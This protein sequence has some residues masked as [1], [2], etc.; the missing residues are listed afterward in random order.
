MSHTLLL[1]HIV[2]STKRREPWLAPEIRSDVFSYM[3]AILRK[4]NANSLLVNGVSD[5]VHIL[6]E[7]PAKFA[8]S[9]VVG[10]V[11]ANS[12]G[13]FHKTFR[14]VAFSWQEGYGAFSVSKSAYDRVFRYVQNQE[15]HHQRMTFESEYVGLLDKHG[16]EYDPRYVLD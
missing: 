10:K 9:D 16:I 12:S 4:Q 1:Y 3:A 11:K 2:F 6:T 13:W 15:R 14:R 8:V 5:H 7:L